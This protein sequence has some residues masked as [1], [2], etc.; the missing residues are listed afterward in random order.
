MLQHFQ[1]DV[2]SLQTFG[3]PLA[4][5]RTPTLFASIPGFWHVHLSLARATRTQVESAHLHTR[6]NALSGELQAVQQALQADVHAVL[7][8]V[9]AVQQDRKFVRWVVAQHRGWKRQE[10]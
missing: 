6:V 9:H 3:F 2:P 1:R 7:Q 4:N 8:G 10:A 5:P